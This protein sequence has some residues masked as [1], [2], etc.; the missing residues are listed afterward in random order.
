MTE[1]QGFIKLKGTVLC[2]HGSSFEVARA[3]V[4]EE[5]FK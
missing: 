4:T 1:K 3:E 2:I 5:G